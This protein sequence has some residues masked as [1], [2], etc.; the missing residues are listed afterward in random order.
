MSNQ[1]L[2]WHQC[3][4]SALAG[5]GLYWVGSTRLAL[6]DFVAGDP[7]EVWCHVDALLDCCTKQHARLVIATPAAYMAPFQATV[8][9][10][11][12]IRIINQCLAAGH[13]PYNWAL[14][15]PMEFEDL[16]FGNLTRRHSSGMLQ[17]KH[18]VSIGEAK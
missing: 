8:V 7:S 1:V 18:I 4:C 11:L 13:Q 6:G 17:K 2:Y 10:I 14:R 3:D 15:N 5:G 16:R 9:T 12:G